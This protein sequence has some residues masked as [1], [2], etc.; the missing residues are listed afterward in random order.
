MHIWVL[1][2]HND[3]QGKVTE[4]NHKE[5]IGFGEGPQKHQEFY[6][7]GEHLFL[8]GHIATYVQ[9]FNRDFLYLTC[10]AF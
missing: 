6:D 3:L 4:W 2:K 7:W 8:L 5:V 1:A 10:T 9:I